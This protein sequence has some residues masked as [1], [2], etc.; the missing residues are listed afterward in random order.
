[1]GRLRR[2]FIYVVGIFT[3]LSQNF[4]EVKQLKLSTMGITCTQKRSFLLRFCQEL[5]HKAKP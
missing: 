4:V 2:L 1:M 5:I 3:F